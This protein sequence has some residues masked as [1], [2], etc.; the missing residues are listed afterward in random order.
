LLD[1]T[2]LK[3]GKAD[4]LLSHKSVELRVTRLPRHD[5]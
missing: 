5:V 2:N 3:I 1:H 4:Q